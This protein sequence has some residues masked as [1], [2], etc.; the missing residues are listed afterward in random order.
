MVEAAG[1]DVY[2]AGSPLMTDSERA[3]ETLVRERTTSPSLALRLSLK[4][5]SPL[6]LTIT[7]T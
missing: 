2:P 5:C 4:I 3:L 6:S 1:L 7:A